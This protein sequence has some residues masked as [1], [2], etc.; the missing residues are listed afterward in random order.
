[1]PPG[2][3]STHVLVVS[4]SMSIS[5]NIGATSTPSKSVRN[6]FRGPLQ[7]HHTLSRNQYQGGAVNSLLNA[8]LSQ[9]VVARQHDC[10]QLCY[11]MADELYMSCLRFCYMVAEEL[12][13]CL[14]LCYMMME[15]L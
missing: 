5:A 14:Q 12:A 7:P 6:P 15:E 3:A 1:M 8:P 9:W 2:M 10:L 11:M 13:S 4:T